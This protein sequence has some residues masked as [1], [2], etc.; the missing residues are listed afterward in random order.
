[1]II[2]VVSRI[3]Y[4]SSFINIYYDDEG[5]SFMTFVSR[6][7]YPKGNNVSKDKGH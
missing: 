6:S 5:T 7:L 4:A 2:H 1:M 3:S